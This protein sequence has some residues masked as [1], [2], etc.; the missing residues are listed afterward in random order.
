MRQEKPS[1]K[2]QLK[3]LVGVIVIGGLLIWMT[4]WLI[5]ASQQVSSPKFDPTVKPVENYTPT[6]GR[7]WKEPN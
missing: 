1:L 2:S 4:V 6:V 7:T 5:L 3:T